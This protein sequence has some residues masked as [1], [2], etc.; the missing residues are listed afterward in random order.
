MLNR[1]IS[2]LCISFV[3]ILGITFACLNSDIVSFNYYLGQSKMPLSLLLV[4]TFC[5]GAV[6]GLLIGL[7][8]Y[9]NEKRRGLST[10]HRLKMAE[11]EVDNLR[12]IPIKDRH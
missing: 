10:K 5:F 2:Y 6:V 9:L 8:L 7:L 4:M 12:A 11:K 1:V 3:V